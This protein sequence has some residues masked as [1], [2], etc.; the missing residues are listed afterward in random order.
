M[1]KK[2]YDVF[3]ADALAIAAELAVLR[4]N[5]AA[6]GRLVASLAQSN[7]EG[8]SAQGLIGDRQTAGVAGGA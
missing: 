2:T 7:P 4:D 6:L 1:R 5:P 3:F 8:P